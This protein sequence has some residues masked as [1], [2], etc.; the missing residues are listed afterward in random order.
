MK[1][2]LID[3]SEVDRSQRGMEPIQIY[4]HFLDHRSNRNQQGR[5][6]TEDLKLAL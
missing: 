5:V 2:H 6:N 4:N 1:F 3:L